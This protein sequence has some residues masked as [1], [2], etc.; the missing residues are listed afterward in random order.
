VFASFF[1]DINPNYVIFVT[2]NKASIS[3]KF[4]IGK[5]VQK[6]EEYDIDYTNDRKYE[7]DEGE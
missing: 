1:E 4:Y 6:Y 3:T 2:T 5:V 7:D